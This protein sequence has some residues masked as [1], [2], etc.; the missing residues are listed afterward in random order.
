MQGLVALR[1]GEGVEVFRIGSDQAASRKASTVSEAVA[2]PDARCLR[3]WPYC[4]RCELLVG[5]DGLHVVAV[6]RD[7]AGG[8]LSVAVESPPGPQGCP[9]SG[10]VAY[11]HGRRDI[12]LVDVPWQ[13]R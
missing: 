9:S 6:E 5:L 4:R 8:G 7:R 1:W 12:G 10:V 3:D 13:H 2:C 11:S